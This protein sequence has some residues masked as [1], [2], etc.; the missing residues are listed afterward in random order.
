M[1]FSSSGQIVTTGW[2]PTPQQV[3]GPILPTNVWTHVVGTYSLT[4]GLRLY[5]NGTLIGST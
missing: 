5:V 2:N 3:I 4:N 1:G